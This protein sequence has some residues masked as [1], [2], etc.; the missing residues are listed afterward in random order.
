VRRI[1]QLEVEQPSSQFAQ[2]RYTTD[3]F[4]VDRAEVEAELPAYYERF[5]DLLAKRR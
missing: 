1:Q 3:E 2:H 4:G 5:G